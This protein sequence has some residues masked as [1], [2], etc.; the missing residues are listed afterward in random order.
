MLD[1]VPDQSFVYGFVFMPIDIPGGSESRPVDLRMALD[2]VVIREAAR[3][4]RD[5]FECSHHCVN[6]LSICSECLEIQAGDKGADRIEVL[7]DVDQS[8]GRFLKGMNCIVQNAGLEQRPQCPPIHDFDWNVEESIDVELQSCVLEN[9]NRPF[10]IKVYKHLNIAACTNFAARHGTEHHG[11]RDSKAPE[12]ALV[13]AEYFED[14]LEIHAHFPSRVYQT[15]AALPVRASRVQHVHLPGRED[16]QR[17][18]ADFRN[19]PQIADAAR[20][21]PLVHLGIRP[22]SRSIFR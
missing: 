20:L 21:N 4:L 6:R 7:D 2:Y 9:A 11:V 22:G 15:N 16:Q 12:I 8:L 3:S 1:R 19:N 14:G 18:Y 5:D 13:R 17:W 10:L